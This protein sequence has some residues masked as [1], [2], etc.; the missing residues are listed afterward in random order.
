LVKSQIQPQSEQKEQSQYSVADERIDES[1]LFRCWNKVQEQV[2]RIKEFNKSQGIK[3][4]DALIG[5]T[6]DG[7]SEPM[8]VK[9]KRRWLNSTTHKRSGKPITINSLL[10][11][12]RISD[13]E[14]DLF[15]DQQYPRI[16]LSA[17][18]R[19]K[20]QEGSEYLMR[21]MRAI[22]LSE[23]GAVVSLPLND[24]DFT[25][26]V[27]VSPD[28]A[29]LPDG[30]DTKVLRIGS[31]EFTFET[32]PKIWITPFTEANVR[33]TVEKYKPVEELRGKVAYAFMK[34]GVANE[35]AVSSLEE[36]INADFDSTFERLRAPQPQINIS[37]KDLSNYVKFDRESK[38]K[39]T[40]YL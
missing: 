20:T 5:H 2:Q 19:I 28:T 10:E 16:E 40:Q 39:H 9:Q 36:F 37:S 8:Q 11:S 32:S 38:E 34:E 18:F 3:D 1:L 4:T 29:K 26:K 13:M 21:H 35:V 7:I 27:P 31:G 25:R 22:G 15:G 17:M 33:A 14:K 24:V 6:Y 23:I 30:N 12:G